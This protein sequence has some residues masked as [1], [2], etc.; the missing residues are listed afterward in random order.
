MQIIIFVMR[1]ITGHMLWE[2]RY[3]PKERLVLFVPFLLCTSRERRIQKT[4][5]PKGQGNWALKRRLINEQINHIL[6]CG[7]EPQKNKT[8][9][10]SLSSN[11]SMRYCNANCRAADYL[12]SRHR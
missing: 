7:W 12:C 6:F 10:K 3:T 1:E 8:Q 9:D 5:C 4:I 11:L 2:N